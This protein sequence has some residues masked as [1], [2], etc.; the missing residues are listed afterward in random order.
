VAGSSGELR[1]SASCGYKETNLVPTPTGYH[2]P[3]SQD[4]SELPLTMDPGS[5]S[6]S[7]KC[8][9]RREGWRCPERPA[10]GDVLC[11]NCR[12]IQPK[13]C[14]QKFGVRNY[15][16]PHEA[17]PGDTGDRNGHEAKNEKR[18]ADTAKTKAAKLAE[19]ST[20]SAIP[21]EGECAW[22]DCKKTAGQ[23]LSLLCSPSLCSRG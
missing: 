11:A 14:Q 17:L 1:G 22:K 16:C 18:R 20:A 9:G 8:L 23:T 2:P 10:T 3:L 21:D 6:S 5:S 7:T 12:A 13:M 19:E 4:A 15:K